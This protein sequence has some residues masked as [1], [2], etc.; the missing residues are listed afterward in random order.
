MEKS[1]NCDLLIH[2]IAH[3]S[4]HTLEKYPKNTVAKE[5]HVGCEISIEKNKVKLPYELWS[6]DKIKP[7]TQTLDKWLKKYAKP[8]SYVISAKLDG[9]SALYTTNE[10]NPHLYTQSSYKTIDEETAQ[11]RWKEHTYN[12]KIVRTYKR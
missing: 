7:S 10:D 6:M 5:G 9:I 3:A 8:K 12:K 11:R 1:K 2:E 4:E